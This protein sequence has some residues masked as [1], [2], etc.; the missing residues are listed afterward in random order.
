MS[1]KEKHKLKMPETIKAK[2]PPVREEKMHTF[3]FANYFNK[4]KEE[5]KNG[6]ST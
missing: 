1:K 6:K 2:K 4:D 5:K 3:S